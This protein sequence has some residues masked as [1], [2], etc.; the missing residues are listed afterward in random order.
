[1]I[2]NRV[3]KKE[4]TGVI[5]SL[6]PRSKTARLCSLSGFDCEAGATPSLRS[7]QA[8]GAKQSP[9]SEKQGDCL[10]ASLLA[11]TPSKS[12]LGKLLLRFNSLQPFLHQR[13][14]QDILLDLQV[15]AGF[16]EDGEGCPRIIFEQA[17][18]VAVANG[19]ILPAH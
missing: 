12:A 11:M 10:V 1:M 8:P 6:P 18:L 13:G 3:L 9:P 19:A 2:F 15:V 14:K 5:A 16:I 4:L 17:P 7:G